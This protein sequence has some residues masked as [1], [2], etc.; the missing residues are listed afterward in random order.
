MKNTDKYDNVN[1]SIQDLN[2][3]VKDLNDN[4]KNLNEK[5]ESISV[6]VN[7]FYYE[8]E[9]IKHQIMLE[10]ELKYY[11]TEVDN[12]KSIVVISKTEIEEM[13][14]KINWAYIEVN[15]GCNN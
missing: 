9:I 14:N 7:D 15:R 1:K 12:I 6:K 4:V 13:L 11:E 2:D 10:E 5:V 8:N 3:N